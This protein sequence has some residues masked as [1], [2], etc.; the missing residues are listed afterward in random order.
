MEDSWHQLTPRTG[1]V[2]RLADRVTDQSWQTLTQ[3]YQ[4]IIGPVAAALY[5]SLFWL[6]E[7]EQLHRHGRL[8]AGLGVDLEHLYAARLRLEATGLLTTTV[9]TANDL[10]TFCYTLRAPLTPARFFNDDLLS[11][12]LLG[13]LGE[14]SYQTLLATATVVTPAADE[15]DITKN[16]LEVFHVDGHELSQLP[17][18]VTAGRHQ[19][20]AKPAEPA[21]DSPATDFDFHLLVEILKR[22]YVDAQALQPYRELLVT[23]H[24]TYGLDEPTMARYIGEATD[25]AT[26]AFDPERFKRVVARHFEQQHPGQ[27]VQSP[28][29][30]TPTPTAVKSTAEQTVLQMASQMTPADFL[31]AI[32]Q[33]TG[34]FVTSGEQRIIRD[35]VGRQLFSQGVLNMMVYHV[36]VDEER[37]TLN[38]ALL[39]TI[40]NDW[41]Q[42]KVATPQQAVVKIRERQ[43]AAKQPRSRATGSRRN[44]TTVKETLPEWAKAPAAT[45][46][47][48]QPQLSDQQKQKLNARIAR[49][50]QRRSGKEDS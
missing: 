18:A 7:R 49:F 28:T 6:P 42:S 46:A 19:I 11:V 29:S 40:A 43:Q 23:E 1:F 47:A 9:K 31:E 13:V 12:Q 33:Q 5:S 3:L 27:P 17:A 32:K 10:T 14:E 45:K 35:L 38:K 41:S 15:Q 44:A 21:V 2:V 24:V 37:P 36:L 48:K 30:P 8:L 34:G 16:F 26:N 39:D 20:T 50:K 25:L 4:P 22:S